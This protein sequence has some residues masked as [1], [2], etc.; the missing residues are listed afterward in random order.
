MQRPN[1][2]EASSQFLSVSEAD[3]TSTESAEGV[4]AAVA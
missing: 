3:G 2:S 1:W 4:A